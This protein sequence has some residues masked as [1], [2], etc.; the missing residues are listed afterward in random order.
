[1]TISHD[2]SCAAT[3][4]AVCLQLRINRPEASRAPVLG[5]ADAHSCGVVVTGA[6]RAEVNEPGGT[7]STLSSDWSVLQLL[8]SKPNHHTSS[9]GKSGVRGHSPESDSLQ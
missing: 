7:W 8:D 3:P 2:R 1:M 9:G 6:G 5:E 4:T